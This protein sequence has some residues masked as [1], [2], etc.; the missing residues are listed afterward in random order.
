MT[1][2]KRRVKKG[3]TSLREQKQTHIRKREHA[4]EEGKKELVSYFDKEIE[5]LQ[6][7]IDEKQDILDRKK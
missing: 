1:N 6:A 4:H 3:L 7:K 5:S 2:R